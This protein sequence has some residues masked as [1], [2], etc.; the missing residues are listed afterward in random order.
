MIS[1]ILIIFKAKAYL[2]LSKRRD[3]GEYVAKKTIN[4]HKKDVV[5]VATLLTNE[6]ECI[7]PQSVKDDM[8][9]FIKEL[10]HNPVEP[11][12]LGIVGPTATDI[13]Y[14]LKKVYCIGG[15]QK[16]PILT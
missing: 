6:D 15:C 3:R 10:T 8:K 1:Y 4:K 14:I 2:D 16:P 13:E 9:E 7:L 11:K 12:V 5:R